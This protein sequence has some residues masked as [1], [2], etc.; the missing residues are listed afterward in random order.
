MVMPEGVGWNNYW[1]IDSEIVRAHTNHN[2]IGRYQRMM[3]PLYIDT[4]QRRVQSRKRYGSKIQYDAKDQ[5]VTRFGDDT[6]GFISAV[7]RDQMA[8]DIV[9][10]QE[11][12]SRDGLI[13]NAT[14]RFLYNGTSFS[15]GTADFSDIPA[16][17]AGEFDVKLLE[18]TALRMST[19]SEYTLKAW[20]DY[21]QPVPGRN[22]RGSS[23]V[24][25]T[26]GTWHGLWNSE[27]NTWMVD[28]RQLQDE[29][30]INGGQV[31]YRRFATLQDTGAGALVLFNAGTITTQ[32]AVTDPIK[33]GDGAPDPGSED[34]V[35]GMYLAGQDGTDT[36]HYIQCSDF[37]AGDF[38]A[39][40]FV[41]IHTK[42]TSSWGIT[43]GN[44]WQDGETMVAEVYEVDADNNRLKVVDPITYAYESLM[45]YEGL[46]DDTTVS[47]ECYAF[48][49]KAQHI[50]P[51]IVVGARESVQFVRRRYKGNLITFHRPVD[52]NVDFPSIER[53]TAEWHGEINQWNPDVIEIYFC[54]AKW[55][56]RGQPAY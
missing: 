50:H 19:R 30:V 40:D 38:V 49:T 1:Y 10:Q 17:E 13:N 44:D 47:G 14:H 5:M 23:L 28:L 7:L 46:D 34:P 43:N 33:W 16:T 45:P 18:D 53:A 2:P 15:N 36:T 32:V 3:G 42:R 41:S 26:T 56:N 9:G 22:F 35:H 25:M 27:A 4:R 54:S 29:R 39:G 24:M 11:K 52:T 8:D 51:V 21:S 31:Q 6:A 37:D 12:I 48:V 55:A 20:G